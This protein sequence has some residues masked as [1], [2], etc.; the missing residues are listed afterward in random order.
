MKTIHVL[1]KPE[2]EVNG[3]HHVC[4]M[5]ET[6]GTGIHRVRDSID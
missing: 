3:C 5:G 6:S 2:M 1:C 4:H